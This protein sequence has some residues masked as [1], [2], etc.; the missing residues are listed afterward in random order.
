[1]PLVIRGWTHRRVVPSGMPSSMISVVQTS[2]SPLRTASTVARPELPSIGRS[3]G[4]RS[5]G[6]GAGWAA[7]PVQ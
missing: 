1:M 3:G 5:D 4:G 2:V 6:G 7:G